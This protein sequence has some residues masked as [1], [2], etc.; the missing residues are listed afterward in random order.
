MNAREILKSAVYNL[1]DMLYGREGVPRV[2][3]GEPY[4]FPAKWCRYFPNVYEPYKFSFLQEHCKPGQDALDIGAHI[5]L[6]SVLMARRIGKGGRLYC[7]EPTKET[8]EVLATILLLNGVQDIAFIRSEAVTAESGSAT[9]FNSDDPA[10]NTNSLL[11]HSEGTHRTS[12]ATTTV[13]EFVDSHG[14]KP[15]VIKI[16]AEGSELDIIKG[17]RRTILRQR[18]AI[19]MELHGSILA[20]SGSSL[21]ELWDTLESLGMLVFRGGQAVNRTWFVSQ[22]KPIEVQILPDD[23]K[24][25]P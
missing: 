25:S 22:R 11:A 19:A 10:S 5:G 6:F 20:S 14:L 7:F 3:S 2:I 1:A 13:D 24:P 16:D 21:Q 9:F 4:R 18:P 15:T 23:R 12:V 17:A 8:R